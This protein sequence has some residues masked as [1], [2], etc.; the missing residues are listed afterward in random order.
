MRNLLIEPILL[1]GDMRRRRSHGCL[2]E[3]VTDPSPS[4]E[5]RVKRSGSNRYPN[6][7]CVWMKL[8]SGSASAS[9]VRSLWT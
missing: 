2:P 9:F 7:K 5:K 4:C 8:H 6:P 3:P 1:I